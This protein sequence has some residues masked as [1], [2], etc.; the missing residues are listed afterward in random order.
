MTARALQLIS[1]RN[2]SKQRAHFAIFLP[3][4]ANPDVGTLIQVVGAPMAG[5]LLEFKRNYAPAATQEPYQAFPIGEVLANDILDS[6][7]GQQIT[8]D[9]PRNSLEREAA[10]LPPPRI[11][12]NF[13][14]PVNNVSRVTTILRVSR[15][16]SHGLLRQRTEGAK[17][18]RRIM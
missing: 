7:D 13:R 3:S 14:A 2:S 11:S 8:D 5:Y 15:Y 18:G 16:L 12:E 17:N 4:A 1:S 9:T 10:R 6:T